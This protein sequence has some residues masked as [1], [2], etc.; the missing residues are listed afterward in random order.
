[1][2]DDLTVMPSEISEAVREFCNKIDLT[3]EPGFIPVKPEFFSSRA[4]CYFNVPQKIKKSNGSQQFG[5]IIWEIPNVLLEAVFHLVWVSPEGEYVDITPLA[6]GE[7]EILF[8]PDSKREYEGH[9]IDNIRQALVENDEMVDEFI[10]LSGRL[11]EIINEYYPENG[12]PGRKMVAFP[13]KAQLEITYI[14][15]R[16]KKLIPYIKELSSAS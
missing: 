10:E 4:D 3:H 9:R 1:M 12:K 14:Q 8:L 13:P 15:S 6:D 5:W 16:M 7:K 2:I 11:N